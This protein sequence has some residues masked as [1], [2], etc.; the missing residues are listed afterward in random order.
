MA[1][2]TVHLHLSHVPVPESRAEGLW[3]SR[4][5]FGDRWVERAG[6][7]FLILYILWLER[8]GNVPD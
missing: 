4:T 1:W 3:L 5:G 7:E 2:C 6:F 8:F